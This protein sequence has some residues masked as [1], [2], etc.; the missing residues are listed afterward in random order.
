M[1][2][3]HLSCYMVNIFKKHHHFSA[4]QIYI[5]L[6][7][8]AITISFAATGN[9]IGYVNSFPSYA[10]YGSFSRK[11]SVCTTSTFDYDPGSN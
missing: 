3:F 5:L 9:S 8:N 1:L 11:D 2:E 10:K 4:S 6:L 7:L